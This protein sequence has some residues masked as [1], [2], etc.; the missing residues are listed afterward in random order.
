MIV[1]INIQ[2]IRFIVHALSVLRKRGIKVI[3]ELLKKII[4]DQLT[5]KKSDLIKIEAMSADLKENI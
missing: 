1:S 5:G 2:K 4:I 3:A